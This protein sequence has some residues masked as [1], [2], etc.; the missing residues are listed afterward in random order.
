M[1]G[2]HVTYE[3]ITE[4]SAESGEAEEQGYELENVSLGEA[5]D[6]LRW[7]GG[8]VEANCSRGPADWFTWYG[9]MDYKTGDYTNYSLHIP[10]HVTTASR[11]RIA[12]YLLK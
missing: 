1:T 10:K 9:E 12:R 8:H 6:F 3:R 11:K 4:E 5:V 2:F 7:Q